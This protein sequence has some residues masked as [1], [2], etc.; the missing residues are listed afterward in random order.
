MGIITFIANTTTGISNLLVFTIT[1]GFVLALAEDI[2][3][4]L[5][6]NK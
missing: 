4:V 1:I 2:K 6:P 5:K 3:A